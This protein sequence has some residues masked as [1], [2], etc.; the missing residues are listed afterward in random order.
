MRKYLILIVLALVFLWGGGQGVYL[1]VTNLSQSKYPVSDYIQ[2]RP[3]SKWVKLTDATLDFTAVTCSSFL[4]FGRT[5]EIYVP[6]IPAGEPKG[7]NVHVLFAT[8]DPQ[9]LEI[10]DRLRNLGSQAEVEAYIKTHKNDLFVRKDV[11]GLVR[12]G[13]NFKSRDRNALEREYPNLS[14]HFV[15]IDDGERPEYVAEGILFLAGIALAVWL[16]V[17]FVNSRRKGAPP[18][19]PSMVDCTSAAK[20]PPLPMHPKN[21]D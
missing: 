1:A 9:L 13:L 16:V 2:S 19:L 6:V 10:A 18:P 11:D 5:E 15:V 20:P 17:I 3:D 4:G 7:R 21:Q 12:W 14:P 8:K